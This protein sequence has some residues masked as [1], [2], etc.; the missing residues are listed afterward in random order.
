MVET[1]LSPKCCFSYPAI[2]FINGV[3]PPRRNHKFCESPLYALILHLVGT[4]NEAGLS[5][6]LEFSLER[7]VTAVRY[8]PRWSD[9]D[10]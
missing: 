9:N 2:Y 10:V 6:L 5:F 8:V 3:S 1:V 4:R 7:L